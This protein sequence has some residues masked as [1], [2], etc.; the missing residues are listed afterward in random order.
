M[1]TSEKDLPDH[2]REWLRAV[3]DPELFMSL[4][5]LGLIYRASIDEKGHA[6]VD[7]TLTSPGCP[8]GDQLV[9]D[10][11]NR[12]KAHEGV[13]SVSVNVVWE[14]KW[15]PATMASDEAKDVLGI[16]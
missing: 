7:F 11:T 8:A 13:T 2:L 12:M 16:W 14:P 5:D 6:N 9:A 3:Q 10:V 15:D 4:V 1:E